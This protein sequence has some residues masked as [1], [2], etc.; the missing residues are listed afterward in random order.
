MT[1]DALRE[2]Y[3]NNWFR[4]VLIDDD[5]YQLVEHA[6]ARGNEMYSH[7]HVTDL[8]MGIRD[9]DIFQIQH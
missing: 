3:S 2:H 7:C 6:L 9:A 1:V 8:E 4:Y 5:E